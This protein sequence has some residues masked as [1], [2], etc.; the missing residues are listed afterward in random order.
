VQHEQREYGPLLRAAERE[1]T[2]V[3]GD[4]QGAEKSELE[5][6]RGSNVTPAPLPFKLIG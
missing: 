6:V 2:A 5:L 3:R 1:R 4:L